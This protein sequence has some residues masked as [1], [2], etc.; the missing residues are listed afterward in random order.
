[1]N[2]RL[3]IISGTFAN[4][5]GIVLSA[6][7]QLVT[8]PILVHAWGQEKYGLWIMLTTV[9]TYFAL[10]DLGFIQ[11][12]TT[13]MTMEEARGKRDSVL[14]TFQSI[15]ILISATVTIVF[16]MFLAFFIFLKYV[17]TNINSYW[18]IEN[19]EIIL[20]LVAYAGIALISRVTL[21]GFRS[22]GNYAFGTLIFDTFVML[23][24][25]AGLLAAHFGGGFEIV[26]AVLIG[27][28]LCSMS[29]FYKLLR[30]RVPWLYLG[31]RE[32]KIEVLK[33]LLR[34]AITA[35]SIPVALAINLQGA[36]LVLGAVLSPSA[37]A[38]YTPVRT[39]GR[40]TIQLIG[41]VNRATM[42]EIAGAKG[43]GA[44]VSLQ[45]LFK[46]NAALVIVILIP[47][48]ILFAIFGSRIV[49]LWT[50]GQIVPSQPFVAMMAVAMMIHGTW[51]FTTNILLAT[52]SHDK[53]SPAMIFCSIL[54]LVIMFYAS[55][56]FGIFG[57]AVGSAISELCYAVII[58]PIAKRVL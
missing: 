52:N 32:A 44:Q 47:G 30:H 23:E 25:V 10:T 58:L 1:M 57:A 13:D 11:A 50:A 43:R 41:S 40:V 56:Y 42:P 36:V 3:R 4:S 22:T 7:L 9:P 38:L 8:V 6:V 2:I 24:G 48:G 14:C 17:F 49:E 27:G 46:L 55:Y 28:R 16:I 18:I 35:L 53:I 39:I 54:S 12:A 21:A 20:S 29:I 26:I 15:W 33:R 31:V 19:L 37:V 5:A 45:R 34:P 51:Y